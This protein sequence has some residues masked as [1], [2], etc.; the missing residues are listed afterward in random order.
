MILNDFL[1]IHTG[2]KRKVIVAFLNVI[3]LTV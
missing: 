3:F 2:I 1:S